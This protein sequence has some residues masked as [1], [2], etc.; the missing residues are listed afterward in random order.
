MAGRDGTSGDKEGKDFKWV[1]ADNGNYKTKKYFTKAEKDAMKNESAPKTSTR[2]Q[3]RA[4]TRSGPAKD[5]P[6]AGKKDIAA[7]AEAAIDRSGPTRPQARPTPTRPRSAPRTA[8]SVATPEVTESKLPKGGSSSGKPFA[9]TKP[10]RSE[11]ENM[12]VGQR[13]RW[14]VVL[15]PRASGGETKSEAP[16]SPTGNT[17]GRRARRAARRSGDYNKGGMVK[18]NCGASMK[19]AQKRG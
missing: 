2:P 3:A 19:P 6:K 1:K 17:A 8:D 5:K 14:G 4:S 18:A 7:I 9:G 15:P 11:W 16:S 12:T 13:V 10:T